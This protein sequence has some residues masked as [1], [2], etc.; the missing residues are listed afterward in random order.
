[1]QTKSRKGEISEAAFQLRCAQMGWVACRPCVE[2]QHYDYI[3]DTGRALVRMQV[4]SSTVR[5][6]QR[7]HNV[8]LGPHQEQNSIYQT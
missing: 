2:K 5:C 1:M 8:T 4:K 3:V 7:R 6:S